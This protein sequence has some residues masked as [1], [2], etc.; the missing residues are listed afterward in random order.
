[1]PYKVLMVEDDK[2]DQMAFTRTVEKEH[3][4]LVAPLRGILRYQFLGEFIV[5]IT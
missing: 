2:L 3:P 4:A 1:M 5:E